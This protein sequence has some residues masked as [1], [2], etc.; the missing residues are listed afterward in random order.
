MW[1]AV[2]TNQEQLCALCGEVHS[3]GECPGT[4]PLPQSRNVA[5]LRSSFGN[6]MW[7]VKQGHHCMSPSGVVPLFRSARLRSTQVSS[8]GLVQQGCVKLEGCDHTYQGT[9]QGTAGVHGNVY[10]TTEP[11]SFALV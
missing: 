1:L 7:R 4:V 2:K 6:K 11:P 9:N 5:P 10:V 3:K 8:F